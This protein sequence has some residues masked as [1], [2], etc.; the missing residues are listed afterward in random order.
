M[1][2]P[3][4]ASDEGATALEFALLLPVFLTLLLGAIDIGKIYF[5]SN[6]LNTA[7]QQ[8]G[9]YAMINASNLNCDTQIQNAAIS[10]ATSLALPTPTATVSTSSQSISSG[11]SGKPAQTLTVTQLSMSIAVPLTGYVFGSSK[12]VTQTYTA[13]RPAPLIVNAQ[14]SCFAFP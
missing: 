6:V 2:K 13:P 9:R 8:A 14:T 1:S 10:V 5:N 7:I 3:R 12:T 4:F 11:I